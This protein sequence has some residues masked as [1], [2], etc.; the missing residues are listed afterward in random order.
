MKSIV[1]AAMILVLPMGALAQPT[2]GVYFDTWP[3]TMHTDVFPATPFTGYLYGH[4]IGCYVTAVE[5]TLLVPGSLFVTNLIYPPNFS[6]D[7]GD[8][9]SGHALTYYPPLNGT[10]PGY[11]LL[12]TIEF[13]TLNNGCA[14]AGGTYVDTP[15]VIVGYPD[16]GLI[17]GTC[18]PDNTIFTF[19]GL[20]SILCPEQI[21]IEEESW[22]AI[23]ALYK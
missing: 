3:G 18:Y 21:G 5:Y 8:P 19:A 16:T 10:I 7:M 14:W 15:I 4:N 12:L 2:L 6:V 23:K 20:T 9:L 22:G 1:I 17:S 13:F 11:N